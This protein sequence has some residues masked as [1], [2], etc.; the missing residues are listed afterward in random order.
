MELPVTDLVRHGKRESPFL[1][2]QRLV[3]AKAPL[4]EPGRSQHIIDAEQFLQ[5][6]QLQNQFEV[7]FGNLI[8]I[9]RR[10]YSRAAPPRI[11][12]E[13]LCD[14]L[15]ELCRCQVGNLDL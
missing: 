10:P 11:V 1:P 6:A 3:D 4:V 8:D 15:I 14:H 7:A 9:D 12:S 13:Q 5:V 2:F